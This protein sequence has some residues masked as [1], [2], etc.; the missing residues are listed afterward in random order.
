MSIVT[1]WEVAI[2]TGMGK[3]TF[4]RDVD[5]ASLLEH[6][7]FTLLPISLHHVAAIRALPPHH[8]DPFDRMLIAQAQ[9]EGFAIVTA[10][11]RFLE[12]DVAVVDAEN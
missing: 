4:P 6:D 1:P 10:D 9:V 8:R 12:Y 2:K 5:I 3:L 7:A 11:R